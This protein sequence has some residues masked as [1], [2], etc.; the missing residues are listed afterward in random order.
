MKRNPYGIRDKMILDNDCR[1][2]I[3]DMHLAIS[4]DRKQE[5]MEEKVRWFMGLTIHERAELLCQFTDMILVI[6]PNIVEQKYAQS[7]PGR[8]L[9]ISKA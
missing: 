1:K 3:K 6:N 2:D 4:H 7:V 5:S 8:I 9:V